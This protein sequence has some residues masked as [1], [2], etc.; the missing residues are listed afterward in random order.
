VKRLG[1][2]LVGLCLLVPAG[3]RGDGGPTAA[4]CAEAYTNAQTLRNARKLVEARDAMRICAA[5]TCK[6]FIVKDCVQWLD[7]VAESLPSVVPVATDAQGNALPNVKVSMDGKPLL[8]KIDGRSLDVDPGQHT[9]AF[10]AADGTKAEKSVL[11][12]EGEHSKRIT[13]TLGP[14]AV[15]AGSTP[16]PPPTASSGTPTTPPATTAPTSGPPLKLIGLV[17]GG[18]GIAGLAV[19]S[20]FGF[21]ALDKKNSAGCS[22]ASVCPSPTAEQTLRDAGSAATI[23]TVGFV[24]GGAL[25]AAGVVLWFVA[26]GAQVQASPTV[27]TESVGLVVKGA[28]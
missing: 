6:D 10:E 3:A 13:V 20:V 17:T 26:P 21:L 27:G 24:A 14:A 7:A 25:A 9:F 8:D 12:T 22:S 2:A 11:V 18:V 16:I 19:G 5:S 28:W 4:A 1:A 23:A 15:P